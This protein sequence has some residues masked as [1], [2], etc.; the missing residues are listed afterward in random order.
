M[1]QFKCHRISWFWIHLLKFVYINL[2]HNLFHN[3]DLLFLNFTI[4]IWAGR[5]FLIVIFKLL[6]LLLFYFLGGVSEF[7]VWIWATWISEPWTRI[8]FYIEINEYLN[9]LKYSNNKKCLW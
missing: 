9:F 2:F 8:I 5:I 3:K 1:Q 6:L 7:T 4:R